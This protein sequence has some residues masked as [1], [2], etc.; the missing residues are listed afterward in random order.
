MHRTHGL[1]L[2]S[3]KGK[4]QLLL[5]RQQSQRQFNANGRGGKTKKKPDYRTKKGEYGV[6]GEDE[7]VVE[8]IW[9]GEGREEFV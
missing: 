6:W 5:R 8:F 1:N 3:R 7:I 2:T 4:G 9:G